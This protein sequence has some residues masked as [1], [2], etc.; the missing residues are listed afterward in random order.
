MSVQSSIP[1]YTY[2]QPDVPRA[3]FTIDDL[4]RIQAALLWTDED[5]RLLRKAGTILAPQIDSI[6]DLWY[7]FVGAHPH[8]IAYFANAQGQPISEYLEA[9]RQRFGQWILDTCQRSYDQDWLNYQYEIGLRHHRTKKN[10]TDG[11]DAVPHV[12]LRYMI[13]FIYPITATIRDFL[14]RGGASPEEVDRMW[15]AWFKAVVLQVVLWSY[16]YARDGDW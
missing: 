7:G 6:L 5:T 3:P 16:P 15:H 4:T 9:V 13:A 12:P 10:R 11:V 14:A 1:G 8:L 2:G